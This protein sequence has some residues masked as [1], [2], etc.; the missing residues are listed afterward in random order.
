MKVDCAGMGGLYDIIVWQSYGWAGQSWFVVVDGDGVIALKK[1]LR[2][3]A[4]GLG[5][6]SVLLWVYAR[7]RFMI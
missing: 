3:S 2:C 5:D 4:V 1:V 6:N 7:K